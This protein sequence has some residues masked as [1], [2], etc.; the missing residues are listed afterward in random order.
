MVAPSS[1]C[2]RDSMRSGRP[3]VTGSAPQPG[4]CPLVR[5]SP[6]EQQEL[7]AAVPRRRNGSDWIRDELR[8]G[9]P[10]PVNGPLTTPALPQWH[11]YIW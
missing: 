6:E 10:R 9:A 4:V 2:A 5:V 7:A 3:P 1:C 8:R 11:A